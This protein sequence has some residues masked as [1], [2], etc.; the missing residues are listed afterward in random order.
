MRADMAKILVERPRLGAGKRARVY[1]Q[2]L[3]EDRAD[4][5]PVREGM[6]RCHSF[7]APTKQLNE[8]LAPL[9]RFLRS[10]LGRPWDQV[11]REIM[12]HVSF[13]NAV[14][15]H[16]LQHLWQYVERHVE[17][18]DGRPVAKIRSRWWRA[19]LHAEFYVDP[20][21][22]LLR[23][24]DHYRMRY[25]PTAEPARFLA[26]DADHQIH[27][28][29]GIWYELTLSPIPPQREQ[30]FDMLYRCRLDAVTNEQLRASFG[31]V[32]YA[33]RKRQLNSR[34]IAK[35]RERLTKLRPADQRVR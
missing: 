23:E 10:R 18:I 25:R 24:N 35:L 6:G 19:D 1:R 21:T 27:R 16:I 17:I 32:K 20:A 11:H 3:R 14:Q 26:I 8:N 34:E 31:V 2:L 28:I 12:Q 7:S 22:G 30:A 4:L 33:S 29:D 13:E 15:Q 9:R 5:L